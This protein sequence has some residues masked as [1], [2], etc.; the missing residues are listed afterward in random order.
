LYLLESLAPAVLRYR[1]APDEFFDKEKKQK[2]KES[3]VIGGVG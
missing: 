1:S 3:F 2:K